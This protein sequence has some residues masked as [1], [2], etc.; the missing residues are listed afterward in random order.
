MLG[1][2]KAHGPYASRQQAIDDVDQMCVDAG[3]MAEHAHS[4]TPAQIDPLGTE[5]VETR[6]NRRRH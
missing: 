4:P 3:R 5:N 2:K 6:G 1:A